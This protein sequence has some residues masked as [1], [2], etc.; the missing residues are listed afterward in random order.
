METTREGL[1]YKAPMIRARVLR[2]EAVLRTVS[3]ERED[4]VVYGLH[5]ALMSP[6]LDGAEAMVFWRGI[7][8]R[9]P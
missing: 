4:R 2:E 6:G 3:G 7:L 5:E 9:A 8:G 1:A